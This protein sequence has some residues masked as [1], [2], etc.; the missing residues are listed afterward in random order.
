[1]KL[2]S[3]IYPAL[4]FVVQILLYIYLLIKYFQTTNKMKRQT[5]FGVP[6]TI[7]SLTSDVNGH[8]LVQALKLSP[9]SRTYMWPW[10]FAPNPTIHAEN[11]ESQNDA[12]N[13]KATIW[14]SFSHI[15][16]GSN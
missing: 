15:D 3:A 11:D 14:A 12:L 7:S 16:R 5:K 6:S 9:S 1:M 13:H 10:Y 4:S 8:V 2:C